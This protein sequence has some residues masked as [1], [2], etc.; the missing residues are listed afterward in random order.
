M[1]KMAEKEIYYYKFKYVDGSEQVFEQDTNELTET[2]SHPERKRIHVDNVIVN[3]EN[4]ITVTVEK[5]SERDEVY[6]Q[7]FQAIADLNF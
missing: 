1:I 7:S 6:T 4:V 5:Q 2:I 3:L